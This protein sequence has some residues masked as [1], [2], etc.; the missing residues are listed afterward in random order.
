MRTSFCILHVQPETES[1]AQV[2]YLGSVESKSIFVDDS[3]K[4]F[5]L[6]KTYFY[7]SREKEQENL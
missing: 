1:I 4:N 3:K 5:Q 6:T 7:V 2:T